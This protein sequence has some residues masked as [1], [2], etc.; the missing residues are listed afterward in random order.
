[1][2]AR[3]GLYVFV[4]DQPPPSLPSES[5]VLTRESA[6]ATDV[7]H[8]NETRGALFSISSHPPFR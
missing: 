1:V 4:S 8:A 2:C 7:P 5:Q 3:A 6:Y